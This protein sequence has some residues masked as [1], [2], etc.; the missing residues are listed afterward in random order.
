MLRPELQDLVQF[1]EGVDA[2]VEAQT[3]VALQYFEDGSVDAACPP[4]KALLHIMAKG[5]Y[6]GKSVDDGSV[7]RLFT[8]EYLMRSEWYGERLRCKQSRDV[9]L[10]TRHLHALQRFQAGGNA[11][12][13]RVAEARAQLARVSAAG[14]LK[15]LEGGLGADP[16]CG[17]G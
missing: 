7:R 17:V 14:Y 8:R 10:W 12:G 16:Y 15:E 3:R 13:E 1:A 6:E 9:A 11:V 4:L 5:Q 2:I